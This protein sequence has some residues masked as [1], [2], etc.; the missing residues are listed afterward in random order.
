MTIDDILSNFPAKAP[1][2]A[3]AMANAGLHCTSCDAAAWET[4]EAGMT[5]HGMEEAEITSLVKELNDILAEESPP[6]DTITITK[7][8]ADKYKS[9]LSEENKEGWGLR[10]AER[11]AGCSGFEYVLDYSEK[12]N[13]D[14]VTLT[15]EGLDIHV[16]K[17]FL[18][19][20]LGSEIDYVD[21][22]RGAGF[23]ITN[24][25]ATSSC[26]CGSSHGY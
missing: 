7:R 19:R 3:Q 16:A 22:L 9:I 6:A 21:G 12:A 17:A 15:S 10:L 13:E 26:G 14:D 20:L 5:S 1:R 11:A 24:P 8:A 4:L 25:N 2:L 18:N 23:K